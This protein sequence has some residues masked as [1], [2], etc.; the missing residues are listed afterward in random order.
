MD[1]KPAGARKKKKKRKTPKPDEAGSAR[2]RVKITR[3]GKFHGKYNLKKL[4]VPKKLWGQVGGKHSYI[5]TVGSTK[6][7]VLL[8]TKAYFINK[9]T[10]TWGQKGAQEAFEDLCHNGVV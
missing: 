7:Q 10:Y 8:N 5:I 4:G 1:K 6:V 3:K 9:K 2:K